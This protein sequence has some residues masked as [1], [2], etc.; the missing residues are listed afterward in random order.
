M[1]NFIEQI[2]AIKTS[3]NF[4]EVHQE[5]VVWLESVSPFAPEIKSCGNPPESV[6][7]NWINKKHS[8]LEVHLIHNSLYPEFWSF[9]LWRWHVNGWLFYPLGVRYFDSDFVNKRVDKSELLE[10]LKFVSEGINLEITV[11]A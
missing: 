5:F 8:K 9:E 4:L 1:S 2:K 7:F 3:E 11:D 6:K 10:C